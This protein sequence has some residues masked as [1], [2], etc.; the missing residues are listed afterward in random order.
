[1]LNILKILKALLTPP[2]CVNW[3]L[4]WS[5][6]M[7]K[8]SVDLETFW[9]LYLWFHRKLVHLHVNSELQT[10]SLWEKCRKK[11]KERP[12]TCLCY[13][14]SSLI[15]LIIHFCLWS[16]C[17]CS[18][19]EIRRQTRVNFPLSEYSDVF[20]SVL[21]QCSQHCLYKL[22]TNWWGREKRRLQRTTKE[23]DRKKLPDRQWGKWRVKDEGSSHHTESDSFGAVYSA[24]LR[25]MQII[26]Q[27]E[28]NYIPSSQD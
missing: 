15:S 28:N 27:L 3:C 1:M 22:E 26:R 9:R 13:L 16:S 17:L 18:P 7:W 5:L 19:C 12:C 11:L 8:G 23:Q 24:E 2:L 20:S 10:C 21:C 25:G 14:Y 6:R 4:G